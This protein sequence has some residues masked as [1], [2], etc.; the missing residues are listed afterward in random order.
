MIWLDMVLKID[1][2]SIA[3]FSFAKVPSSAT[4]I[5]MAVPTLEA[6]IRKRH[7]IRMTYQRPT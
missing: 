1:V 2:S 7:I 3:H 6:N 4:A 5:N